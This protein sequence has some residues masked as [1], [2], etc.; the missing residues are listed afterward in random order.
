LQYKIHLWSKLRDGIYLFVNWQLDPRINRE[1][2]IN[3]V[4]LRVLG[5]CSC[6]AL[7][8]C[9]HAGVRALRGETCK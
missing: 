2:L 5:N 1:P 9:V 8:T 6:V 4:F 3:S 7:T